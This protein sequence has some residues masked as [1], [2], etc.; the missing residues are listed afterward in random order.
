[1]RWRSSR[2]STNVEDR[3]GGGV[4]RVGRAA[5]GGGIGIV[6]I[7]LVAMF[8]GV[9]PGLILGL[10]GGTQAP[11]IQQT[12]APPGNDEAAQFVAAV[13]AETE[14]TWRPIFEE[15]LG[16][17]YR[18]PAL[19]LFDRQVNSACGMATAATG[20]FYCPGDQKVYLD[21]SFF[22][23]LSTRFGAPGDFAQAYVIAHEV[24]HHVQTLLG[25]SEQVQS[26]R[27]RS[28]E[29]EANRLSVMME[30]QADCFSGVWARTAHEAR[31]ILERGDIEEGLG[32]ASAIGDDRLQRQAR[33][34]VTPDS[35]THGT[36]EQRVRWFTTGLQTGDINSCNT[37][38]A[39]QL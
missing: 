11:P 23:E 8:F 36:S 35:F 39:P 28:S 14:D 5:G 15:Q 27:Q 22:N 24:G 20:P 26:A 4:G 13:L 1:M 7:A 3:R 19:V 9:D 30:L 38:Q 29:V 34:Y 12:S 32:A 16:M 18:E 2:R 25:I 33:G 17:T 31:G 37:F 10:S 6:L 21:L